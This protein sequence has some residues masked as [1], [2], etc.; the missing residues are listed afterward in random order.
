MKTYGALD[1]G[2]Q[3]YSPAPLAPGRYPLA[4]TGR[5]AEKAPD[6]VWTLWSSEKFSHAG[7]RIPA[8][9]LVVILTEQPRLST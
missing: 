4:P 8:A 7:N 2:G 6:Q 3:L 9:E 5:N 1:G